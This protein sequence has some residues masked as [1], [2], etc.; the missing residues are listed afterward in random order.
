MAKLGID[1]RAAEA[2]LNHLSARPALTRVY[3]RHDYAGEALTA[4]QAWQEH[5]AKLIEADRR[6]GEAVA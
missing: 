3:D 1:D 6:D 2:A 5:V 4:L